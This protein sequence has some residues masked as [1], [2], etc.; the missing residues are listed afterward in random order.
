MNEN[1][2]GDSLAAK[3]Q[4]GIETITPEMAQMYLNK[5]IGNRQLSKATVASY[6]QLMRDDLWEVNNDAICF[7][8][9][10]RLLNGQ[11]RLSAV[12][13]SGKPIQFAVIRGLGDDSFV[14]MDNG[15]NRI[16]AD[17]FYTFGIDNGAAIAPVVKRNIVLGQRAIAINS[18]SGG[19]V[20]RIKVSNKLILEEYYNHREKYN[21]ITGIGRSLYKR[22]RLFSASDYGGTMAYLIITLRHPQETAVSFFEEFT[23]KK[24]TTSNAVMLLRR[25]LMQDAISTSKLTANARQ[26]LL[27]KSWNAYVSGKEMKSLVY[28]E[29]NDK[30]I[31]FV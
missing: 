17:A 10:G 22:S 26:K 12:V 11:H 23:E 28:N 30:N 8:A 13:E 29:I 20:A 6:A 4:F 27:I 21:E 18:P 3:I 1:K 19:N 16:A 5:N 31:W 14:T 9:S 25:R 7:N 2:T 15:K 24:P